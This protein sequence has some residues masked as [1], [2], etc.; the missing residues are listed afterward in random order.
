VE[1]LGINQLEFCNLAVEDRTGLWME[2]FSN[3]PFL[4][5]WVTHLDPPVKALAG[6]VSQRTGGVPTAFDQESAIRFCRALYE[7]EI[8]NGMAYQT[9]SGFL[10]EYAPGQDIKYPRDVLRDKS[11]TCV[12]L[13]ILFAS[14]CEAVGLE[15]LLVTLPGHCFPVVLLP[16]GGMLPVECTAI[17]GVAVGESQVKALP[18]EQ[19]VELAS[20]QFQQ[21][22]IG[23]CYVIDVRTMWQQGVV[24]PE[25]STLEADILAKWGWQLRGAQTPGTPVVGGGE[26]GTPQTMPTTST[27]PY[28]D[29]QQKFS[30]LYPEGWTIQQ[31]EGA[32]SVVEPQD[33]AWITIWR[34]AGNVDPQTFLQDMESQLQQRYPDFTVTSGEHTNV[35]GLDAIRFDARSVS[36]QG[37]PQIHAL[38]VLHQGNSVQLAVVSAVLGEHHESLSSLLE[39]VFS[40]ITLLP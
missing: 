38:L 2:Y 29:E 13:A 6:M 4:A 39:Q 16:G 32:V 40:S 17:S 24:S 33:R 22:Q 10:E 8:A 1:I 27:Q 37:A 30:F 20:Q 28:T 11:G 23:A 26:T 5:A 34:V 14:A 21:L 36:A 15:T 35:G 7:L 31:Q 3:S 18:F 19:A 9:P 12:D 25:L